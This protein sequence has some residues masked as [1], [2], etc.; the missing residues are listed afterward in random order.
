[1]S[2]TEP[3][4]TVQHTELY[5]EQ[6][7]ADSDAAD[8]PDAVPEASSGPTDSTDL[9]TEFHAAEEPAEED[10]ETDSAECQLS[11]I[12][13][14]TAPTPSSAADMEMQQ[15]VEADADSIGDSRPVSVQQQQSDVSQQDVP[16]ALLNESAVSASHQQTP[17]DRT[18]LA[19]SAGEYDV[20]QAE[21]GINLLEDPMMEDEPQSALASSTLDNAERDVP[22]AYAAALSN[23]ELDPDH[24]L[25]A[26]AQNAL[27]KQ[28]L[29]I[30][31]R[32][33]SDVREKAVA[34]QVPQPCLLCHRARSDCSHYL[35]QR[36]CPLMASIA[37]PEASNP[38][39]RLYFQLVT[40]GP[41]IPKQP[42][43]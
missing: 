32:L 37:A 19:S 9:Q 40:H 5:A 28:L 31:Y 24:P 16:D 27:A 34:L 20:M 12:A 36:Y 41:T 25:L 4:P 30:K 38:S 29:A 3:E 35:L 33:E 1:M 17:E 42:P 23:P 8:P 43:C 11:P 21:A 15:S 39:N 10:T 18:Q 6:H 2:D 7:T 14:N 13:G 22:A 26:R